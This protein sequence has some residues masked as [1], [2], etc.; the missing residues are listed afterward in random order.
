L[1][2]WLQLVGCPSGNRA[3]YRLG[4]ITVIGAQ[5]CAAGY[6]EKQWALYLRTFLLGLRFF[7]FPLTFQLEL[8][9]LVGEQIAKAISALL[10][11]STAAASPWIKQ[12]VVAR[13]KHFSS[14]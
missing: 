3:G 11:V 12:L 8:G 2:Y 6:S 9:K 1:L 4:D 7:S 13:F 14:K 10:A 5:G